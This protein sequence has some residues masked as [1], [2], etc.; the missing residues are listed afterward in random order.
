MDVG[1]GVE[2]L[3]NTTNFFWRYKMI[4]VPRNPGKAFRIFQALKDAVPAG[5]N[6]D[7]DIAAPARQIF[8][9][10]GWTLEFT[11]WDDVYQLYVVLLQMSEHFDFV[12]EK[13]KKKK[14]IEDQ[15]TN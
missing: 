13:K 12:M 11:N 4:L 3:S 10:E 6:W 9:E 7:A 15:I 8:E 14:K 5:D 1:F 2:L